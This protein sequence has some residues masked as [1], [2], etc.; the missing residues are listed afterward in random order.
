V[1]GGE[2]RFWGVRPQI[3]GGP[4]RKDAAAKT[5]A[6]AACSNSTAQ[7]CLWN[8]CAQLM[9]CSGSC[10]TECKSWGSFPFSVLIS[11]PHYSSSE[12][13]SSAGKVPPAALLGCRKCRKIKQPLQH[14]IIS[15]TPIPQN[16][17]IM[18]PAQSSAHPVSAN[19]A[20]FPFFLFL[21]PSNSSCMSSTHAEVMTPPSN[22]LRV[23]CVELQYF[24]Y[25][26]SGVSQ[27]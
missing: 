1:V 21:V 20:F 18:L 17:R 24:R 25:G 16:G 14:R 22:V 4:R 12:A 26:A 7:L 6:S 13:E 10:G 23:P 19:H 2:H 27:G 5:I 3:S 8:G 15:Q 11:S 9:L